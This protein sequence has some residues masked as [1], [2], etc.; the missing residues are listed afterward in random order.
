MQKARHANATVT[1]C[2]SQS[3]NL[4]KHCL[5][6]DILIAALGSPEFVKSHMVR[7]GATV[8]DVGVNRV[9]DA[10]H[11]GGSCLVGDVD[12]KA[13]QKKAFKITPNPGGV[14]PMTIAMLL[15]NTVTAAQMSKK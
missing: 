14:G 10:S 4:E 15:R 5:Q 1:V 6:A 13:V 12:F 7:E 9:L 8:V 11:S 2:H 3:K